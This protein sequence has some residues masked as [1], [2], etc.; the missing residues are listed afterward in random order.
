[1][2]SQATTPNLPQLS[3]TQSGSQVA[4]IDEVRE[5]MHALANILIDAFLQDRKRT[6]EPKKE[7]TGAGLQ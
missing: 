2:L 6:R 5:Q 3:G 4:I 7:G 1:M